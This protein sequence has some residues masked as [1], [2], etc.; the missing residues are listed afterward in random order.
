[1]KFIAR[2]TVRGLCAAV[3]LFAGPAE[4][5]QQIKPGWNLFTPAQDVQLGQEA[6]TEIEKQ[7]KVVNDERL[8]NYVARIGKR[9]ADA[10]P[11]PDYPYTFK[12][13]ADPSINAFALPG[14][15]IYIH[16]GLMTS[17]D[18][19]A[20]MVGVLAH[21]VGHVALRHS[22][23][24]ASKAQMFQLPLALAG[25]FLDKK[26]GM[27]AGLA[28]MGIGFGVNSVFLRYSRKAEKQADILGARM[29]AEAGYDPVE[30][31][32]FFQKLGESGGGGRMPQFFSDHPNPGN[33]V[34]YVEEELQYL[35]A[36]DYTKGNAREFESMKARAAKVKIP[37][38]QAA[39]QAGSAQGESVKQSGAGNSA[40]AAEGTQRYRGAGYELSVPSSWKVYEANEGAAVTITPPNGLVQ[41]GSGSPALARGVMAGYVASSGRG[42][43]SDTQ[44]LL[45]DFQN[46]NPGLAPVR[47]QHRTT[48]MH[49]QAAESILMAGQSPVDNQSELVWVVTT[50]RPN[51]LF[52]IAFVAPESEYNGLRT[53]YEEMLGTVA[54]Y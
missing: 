7:V 46:S 31:A 41:T 24:Q 4:A 39:P 51:S 26:G 54:F 30:M 6:A 52:Y 49:G 44:A 21:E 36:R 14:G 50:L 25:G 16:T 11:A 18:N 48:A 45:A 15:P 2:S 40:P 37:K 3:I 43:G 29:M 19:E 12:V 8:T 47:G 28:Q 22:T 38:P 32:T 1:M 35:P 13:V 23:N 42:L 33:R 27:L 5:Q 9:L 20:Q 53:R 10:S 34:R 17:S